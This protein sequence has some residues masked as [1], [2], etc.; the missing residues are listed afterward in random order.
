MAQLPG[1]PHRL[2]EVVVDARGVR[3]VAGHHGVARRTTDRGGRVRVEKERAALGEP[4]DVGRADIWVAAKRPYPVILIIEGDHDD[5]RAG[6]CCEKRAE[7]NTAQHDDADHS[8][9]EL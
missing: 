2:V 8:D 6:A 4:I 7:D 1:R 3:R 5:I 9:H